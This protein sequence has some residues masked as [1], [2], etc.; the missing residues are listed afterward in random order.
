[1]GFEETRAL[2]EQVKTL[3]ANQRGTFI[4][5]LVV[6]LIRDISYYV[7]VG[8]L[9]WSLGRRIVQAILTAAR[10]SRRQNA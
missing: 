10:E 2:I 4:A 9:V 3:D 7:V 5:W 1:M 8:I 6:S